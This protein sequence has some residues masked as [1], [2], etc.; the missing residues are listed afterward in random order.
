MKTVMVRGGSRD[1]V[2]RRLY[3]VVEQ[4]K[5]SGVTLEELELA[6]LDLSFQIR[7]ELLERKGV[8]LYQEE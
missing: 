1:E 7:L 6:L 5:G 4:L 8:R 3:R 2:R